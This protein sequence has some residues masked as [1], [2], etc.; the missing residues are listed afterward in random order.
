V[1]LPSVRIDAGTAV[2]PY[3]IER[4]LSP[5]GATARHLARGEDGERVV[6]EVFEP[7][8]G[9]GAARARLVREIRALA[10]IE[11]RHLG[12]VRAAGENDG[13]LWIASEYVQGTDLGRVLV[14][15]GWQPFDM[16]LSYVAQ[17]AEG[18]V[19]AHGAGIV[20]R[21]L[22]PSKLRL[23][24]DGRVVVVGFGIATHRPDQ[25]DASDVSDVA[26][27]TPYVSPEQIE[28]SLADER[29]DVWAL[30][31]I[32]YELLAGVPPF[33]R[34]GRE[35]TEAIL[36]DEPQW[37]ERVAGP[38]V[39][40]ISACLRK[41]SFAR[42]GTMRE[43][44]GL[45]RDVS[46]GTQPTHGSSA[47]SPAFASD[48]AL[49]S[50]RRASIRPSTRPSVP[51]PS[52]SGVNISG[53]AS[54][55]SS[56]PRM[57]SAPL[58]VPVA[59]R[60]GSRPPPRPASRPPSRPPSLAPPRPATFPP[61]MPTTMAPVIPPSF[62]PSFPPS[63]P[64]SLP[65]LAGPA[66]TRP[67]VNLGRIKGTAVRAGLTWY[68]STYGATVLTRVGALASPGLQ[69]TL[70]LQD[71]EFGIMP[72]GWYDTSVIGE[73]LELLDRVASGSP[74]DSDE[75]Y[76]KLARAIAQ[77]NVS[78]VYRSLF[79]LVASPEMFVLHAQ[80]VWRTYIDEG[81]LSVQIQ[82]PGSFEAQVVGW[83]RH[84]AEVCRFLRPLVENL[85]REVGYT[86]LVVERT[87]C[88]ADGDTCC[89]FEGSW[90]AG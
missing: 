87:R 90:M 12:R 82:G 49:S 69:A 89:A 62:A 65:P 13:R 55:P 41:S 85:L 72:S 8:A 58:V 57:P 19:V 68:A 63:V 44:L 83:S 25:R 64:P 7:D 15:R 17:A 86:A 80:R 40:V 21:D 28:H 77:D 59:A 74:S 53:S 29:S 4:G 66:P 54:R 70:R 22:T 73:L 31:C 27:A 10:A 51:P 18:L 16:A 11:H 56:P 38:V 32:L 88:V 45:L 81:T 61:S 43:M 50:S 24:R 39:H 2:G 36:R 76:G 6:L 5:T 14:E 9:T 75:L 52:A 46:E 71:P 3:L 37:T 33:G 79:R 60:I 1:T 42:V 20:H 47:S 23:M 26:A 30:G 67:P 35:T 78:G 84:N 34:G 48:R